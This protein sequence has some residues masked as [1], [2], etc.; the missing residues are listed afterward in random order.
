MKYAL[1][2]IP[3]APASPY[4]DCVITANFPNPETLPVLGEASIDEE[5]R[6]VAR[7][8]ARLQ[9]AIAESD[10]VSE[11][12]LILHEVV[13]YLR[14]NCRH[15]E[16]WMTRDVYPNIQAH[17]A[18]HKSLFARLEWMD[19]ILINAG[20]SASLEALAEIT[21]DLYNHITWDDRQIV[22]W[23]RAHTTD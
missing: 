12:R 17:L 13:S 15:E 23:H 10:A 2:G 20:A 11:Q 9:S 19:E 8:L 6:T 18:S 1:L 5:H 4:S 3:A 16:E 7:H 21:M 22:A 14:V